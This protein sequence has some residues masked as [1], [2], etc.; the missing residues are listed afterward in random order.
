MEAMSEVYVEQDEQ[1]TTE[2]A[3][4]LHCNTLEY[5]CMIFWYVCEG[6]DE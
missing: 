1:E 3:P 5:V 6:S 4:Y 2:K